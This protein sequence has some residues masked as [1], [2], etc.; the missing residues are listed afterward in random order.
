ML[1]ARSSRHCIAFGQSQFTILLPRKLSNTVLE[2]VSAAIR[3]YTSDQEGPSEELSFPRPLSQALHILARGATA[4]SDHL[5]QLS[6]HD[7]SRSWQPKK[8]GRDNS[9]NEGL[10]PAPPSPLI[11]SLLLFSLLFSVVIQDLS[12]VC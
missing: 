10:L 3:L 2:A 5:M 6:T 9:I 11:C 1:M 8:R 7:D 12:L 4:K